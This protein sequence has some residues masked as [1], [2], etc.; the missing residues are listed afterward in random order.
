MD[1]VVIVQILYTR[2]YGPINDRFCQIKIRADSLK[3]Q[4]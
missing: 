4:V 3:G 2:Q 1:D